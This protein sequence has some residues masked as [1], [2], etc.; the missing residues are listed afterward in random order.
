V[1]KRRTK[2]LYEVYYWNGFWVIT[3]NGGETPNMRLMVCPVGEDKSRW[4]DIILAEDGSKPFDGGYDRLL[5]SV[6][7]FKG[8]L[9]MEGRFR[10]IPAVW[11][12]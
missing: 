10:G 8:H 2:V 5:D 1:A 7:S 3:S 9:V 11:S 12:G 4:D 6:Q